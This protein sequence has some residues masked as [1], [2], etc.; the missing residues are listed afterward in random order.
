[1]EVL[2]RTFLLTTAAALMAGCFNPASPT[3]TYACGDGGTCPDN[4]TCNTTDNF[5][6]RN[7][8][9][10]AACDYP[11]LDLTVVNDQSAAA[12]ASLPPDLATPADLSGRDLSATVD[13]LVPPDLTATVDLSTDD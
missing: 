6:H 8:R 11:I 5:C 9:L 13:M 12:D 7:D 1:M 2:M 4:Y 3:C 10:T